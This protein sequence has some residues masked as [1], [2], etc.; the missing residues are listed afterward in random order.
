[1]KVLGGQCLLSGEGR[2]ENQSCTHTQERGSGERR[3]PSGGQQKQAGWAAGCRA[4]RRQEGRNK[5]GPRKRIGLDIP[6]GGLHAAE[7][8]AQGSRKTAC[9]RRGGTGGAEREGVVASAQE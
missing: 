2:E 1:M 4:N 9:A 8:A 6:Q 3:E 7:G 5:N